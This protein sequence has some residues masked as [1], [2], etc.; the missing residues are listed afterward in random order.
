MAD[1]SS[2]P[3]NENSALI[4]RNAEG[5]TKGWLDK[6]EEAGKY[7]GEAAAVNWKPI[8]DKYYYE[9]KINATDFTNISVYS[10]MLYN[11]NAYEVQTLEYSLDGVE[12]KEAGR[13]TIPGN[14]VWTPLEVTLHGPGL[15]EDSIGHALIS[16]AL[17]LGL[18]RKSVV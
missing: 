6:S 3:D 12:Y 17:Y 15:D 13:I 14:K 16:D 18:D 7:E 10:R 5:I 2:T 8:A 4:L 11:Y 9:T 1:F